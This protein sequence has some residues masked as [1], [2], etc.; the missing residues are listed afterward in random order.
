MGK[1]K[2]RKGF[3]AVV[4]TMVLIMALVLGISSTV[5]SQSEGDVSI[6]EEAYVQLEGEYVQQL[7][8]MLSD[9]GY[10]NCGINLTRVVDVGGERAYSIVL[11]HKY[12]DKLTGEQAQSLFAELGSMA[13]QLANCSFVFYI[14]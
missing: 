6:S 14:D 4:L 13:F 11:H 8:S 9:R 3:V 10:E 5:S 2:L 7:R 1:M 12:L